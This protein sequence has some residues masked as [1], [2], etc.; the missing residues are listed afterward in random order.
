M[1]SKFL[2][3]I[4]AL[5][6]GA[7]GS[8]LWELI[9]PL[10]VWVSTASLDIVTLGLDSL[11]DGLYAD[12]AS[13]ETE[14]VSYS[15]LS[16]ITGIVTGIIVSALMFSRLKRR[17]KANMDL[18]M[19]QDPAT[20]KATAQA[21]IARL[22]RI[23]F[24]AIALVA[25]SLSAQVFM[26]QRTI[27]ISRAAAHFNRLCAIAEPH[28]DQGELALIKSSFAQMSTRAEYI[29]LTNRL[30]AISRANKAKVPDFLIY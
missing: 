3:I 13:L 20:R 4:G 28:I 14:R 23:R 2:T 26:A 8:G 6:L 10:F 15:I 5:I 19:A 25:L 22:Q 18:V 21:K 24:V 27:Y 7:L 29:D 30:S 9:K 16:A 1:K 12:A 17:D 11:R